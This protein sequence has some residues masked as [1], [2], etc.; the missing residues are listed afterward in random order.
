[1][2][3]AKPYVPQEGILPVVTLWQIYMAIGIAVAP[4]AVDQAQRLNKGKK[5]EELIATV[6][7]IIKHTWALWLHSH[8]IDLFRESL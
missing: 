3:A 7:G 8:V 1:M 4:F 2:K 5:L 6:L